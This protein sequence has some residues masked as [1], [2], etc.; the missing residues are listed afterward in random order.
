MK[1]TFKQFLEDVTIDDSAY[2]KDDSDRAITDTSTRQG[3]RLAT[4]PWK[5]L[6]VQHKFPVPGF[7]IKY[8]KQK[9]AN[10]VGGKTFDIALFDDSNGKIAVTIDGSA[11]D[12]VLPGGKVL[13]LTTE[14]LSSSAMYRGKGLVLELYKSLIAN[15]QNIFSASL[16][17]TGG[18]SVW[19]RLI[20]DNSGIVFGVIP[21]SDLHVKA[22]WIDDYDFGLVHGSVDEMSKRVYGSG[23]AFW[24]I[25]QDPG[26]LMKY[27]VK[28]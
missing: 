10:W 1:I 25:T 21:T 24:M 18:A 13:G 16:Q 19:K 7:T 15:G 20:R 2:G 14:Q 4:A 26:N 5:V 8:N 9:S 27:A 28:V 22:K 3:N 17:T 11:H 12:Y 23:D 6:E